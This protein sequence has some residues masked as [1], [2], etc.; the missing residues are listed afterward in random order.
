MTPEIHPYW[1]VW[2]KKTHH[3][4]IKKVFQNS[5]VSVTGFY[6]G[7]LS[8][9]FTCNYRN[10]SCLHTKQHFFALGFSSFFLFSFKEKNSF[11]PRK[12]TLSSF[13]CWALCFFSLYIAVWRQHLFSSNAQQWQ[14]SVH[15][16]VTSRGTSPAGA[17]HCWYWRNSWEN[18]S[19][20]V[21]YS[22]VAHCVCFD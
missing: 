12:Q 11:H 7:C 1:H 18:S 6:Q 15:K 3:D 20:S 22:Y 2:K 9:V 14:M 13:C 21:Y 4:G 10:Y 8:E 16:E 19:W 17:N 5:S